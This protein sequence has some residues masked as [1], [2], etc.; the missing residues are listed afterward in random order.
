MINIVGKQFTLTDSIK[1]HI[2]NSFETL[3]KYN[4]DIISS[5]CVI[6][7]D[8]RAGKKGYNVDLSINLAKKE[9]IVITH[10]DKDVYNA[11]DNII[12]RASKVLR[13]YHDKDFTHKNED[14][15]KDKITNK[16]VD[17]SND[18]DIDEIVPT[19]PNT[20]KPLE[21]DEALKILKDSSDQ[22]FVFYDLDLKMRVL[23]KRKDSKFG[24]F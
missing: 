20:F 23:Y 8:E 11:I 2:N 5:R 1:Q 3:S 16:D 13:R 10:K 22:F 21:I 9:T 12:S 19:E 24:L 6:S 7:A 4:L 15:I 14:F 17:I 18:L